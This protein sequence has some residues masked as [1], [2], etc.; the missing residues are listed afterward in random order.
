MTRPVPAGDGRRLRRDKNREAVID[1]LLDLFRDGVYQPSSA[2]IA[3]KAGLSPRS[4]FRYFDDVQ[5]LHQAA[6]A[7]QVLLVRGL[8]RLGASPQDPT[9]DKI[10]AV[11]RA[12]T[13]LFEQVAPAARALRMAVQRRD[14]LASELARNRGYLRGQVSDLFAPE[15]AGPASAVLPALQVLCSFESYDL[16]RHDQQLSRAGAEAALTAA[17]SALLGV[18]AGAAAP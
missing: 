13:R 12:R 16:L 17:M 5:D 3:A 1:A 4:L 7:R 9:I 15:L 10:R 14:E 2:Q 6:A 18:G 8:I 11:V